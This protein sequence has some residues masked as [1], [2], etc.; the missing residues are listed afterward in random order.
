MRAW[1]FAGGIV[2]CGCG[3]GGDRGTAAPT[4]D[5]G[6]DAPIDAPAVTEWPVAVD[7]R[8]PAGRL[9]PA[10]LGHYDLSGSLY[11]YDQKAPAIARMKALGFPEWR[12]G[13]GRWEVATRLLPALADGKLTSC[14]AVL[15]ALPAS[16]AAPPGAT[17]A[18]L[19]AD[20]D[21]FSDDGKEVTLADTDVDARYRLAYV[22]KV[23]DV[24][25]AYG[26]T[27]YVDVDHMPRALS[28]NR[29]FSRG[30]TVEGLTDPCL[31]TWTNR[32]SNA[33][34]ASADVF[35]AAVVGLVRRVVEGTPGE[36]GREAPYWEVWNEPDLAFG[37]DPSLEQPPG[38]LNA[39]F[40]M[41]ANTLVRLDAYRKGSASARV[42]A[43]RF[44][45]GGFARAATAVKV[46]TDFD[47]TSLPGVGRL[48]FDFVSFH[49]Y[50]NDPEQIL[51]DVRAV[52]AARAA[53][54]GYGSLELVLSEWGPD[55]GKA[56]PATAIDTSLL[57]ATVLARG[58]HLGLSRTHHALFYDFAPGIPYTLL[59]EDGAPK[60]LYYAYQLLH[61]AIGA[62]GDRLAVAGAPEGALEGGAG[63]VLASRPDGQAP[64]LLVVN[65]G[66][67]PRGI[68]P[69]LGSGPVV[70][71]RVLVFD[72]PS[73]PPREVP[74]A[75][76][77]V[78]PGRSIALVVL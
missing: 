29:V 44:G 11:G 51:A 48:P 73:R 67:E 41:A 72:D 46:V 34:P 33:R 14:A 16:L 60:P 68:R 9:L 74:P 25:A 49:S 27:P 65:R 71:S 2:L 4:P 15:A 3:G 45:M 22:R 55:L 63:A 66:G 12:V 57:V 10:L 7:A 24:A 76:P 40:G 31:G 36:P 54:S 75:L 17:D 77:V 39:Y 42:K 26:A 28:A 8:A 61:E 58:A 37:W 69:D 70:P 19:V 5:A 21:W 64:R 47:K 13:V 6:T 59:A 1:I 78:V 20:R 18:T 30:G 53:S 56:P 52:A 23:L 38:S 50:S 62:G 32:V 43:L 35:G